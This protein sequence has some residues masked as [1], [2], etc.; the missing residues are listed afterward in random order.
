MADIAPLVHIVDD[1]PAVLQSLKR[2]LGAWGIRV[3][4][5]ASGEEF[6]SSLKTAPNPECSVIDVQMPGMTGLEVQERLNR[7][8]CDIPVIFITAHDE[9]GMEKHA[10][11]AGAVGFLR[12]PFS[13]ESLVNLILGSVLR[14]RLRAN[15]S[16]RAWEMVP[17]LDSPAD[18]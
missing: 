5:F 15:A 12:K 4:A 9:E 2:L 16:N 18:P 8:G 13:E 10:L 1:D 6:L 17:A 7:S 11:Q 14:R 3:V